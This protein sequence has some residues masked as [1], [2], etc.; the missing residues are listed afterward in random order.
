MA[1]IAYNPFVVGLGLDENTAAFIDSDNVIE[2]VGNG[3]ITVIDVSQLGWSGMA[4][5][6]TGAPVGLIGVKLHVLPHG[7]LFSLETREATPPGVP[8]KRKR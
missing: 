3:A 4:T 6:R 2:V 5:A 8:V 7:A 1:A